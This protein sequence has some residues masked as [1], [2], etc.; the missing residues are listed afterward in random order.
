MPVV[1]GAGVDAGQH[2]GI[3]AAVAWHDSTLRGA[4]G[5]QGGR[6][7]TPQAPGAARRRARS[8]RRPA[9]RRGA[10]DR[11]RRPRRPCSRA[12][13]PSVRFRSAS[14]R[15]NDVTLAVAHPLAGD[16]L[17]PGE[18]PQPVRAGHGGSLGRQILKCLSLSFLVRTQTSSS[19]FRME[20]S[21]FQSRGQQRSRV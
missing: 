3:L 14:V 21:R 17:G 11:P 10:Q 15:P 16:G 8:R 18:L 5:P 2:N 19:S 1:S 20:S 9:E 6:P 7:G 12:I 13:S 4:A